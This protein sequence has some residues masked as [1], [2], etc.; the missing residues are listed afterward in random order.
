MRTLDNHK[1]LMYWKGM[2][3]L[4]KHW[5][6]MREKEWALNVSACRKA[7]DAA[8]R[9]AEQRK[10]DEKVLYMAILSNGESFP[11]TQGYVRQHGLI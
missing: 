11:V 1:F 3:P 9:A 2:V 8:Y 10:E 6:A 5:I 4:R 7:S